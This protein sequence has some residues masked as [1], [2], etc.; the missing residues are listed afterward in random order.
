MLCA[1]IMTP[2]PHSVRDSDSIG[3]A[4]ELILQH[5]LISLPV[6]D[7]E[8]KLAG[9]F[10]LHELLGLLVPRVAL[11]G[12]RLAN[13][14]FMS[15]DFAEL[16]GNLEA[17]RHTPVRRAVNRDAPS[18]TPQTPVAEALR[19]FCRNH[20]TL[21]V[22]ESASRRVVGIVSYWDAMSALATVPKP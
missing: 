5:R 22:V 8:G 13:S 19:L 14:H 11:A 21:P 18:V 10:G 20:T 15:G 6:V 4:A 9:T 2:N 17:D 12:D 16:R 7:A 1:D 3:R